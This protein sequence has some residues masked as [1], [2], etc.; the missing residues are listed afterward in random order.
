MQ[1]IRKQACSLSLSKIFEALS[2]SL[3]YCSQPSLFS[4]IRKQRNFRWSNVF[5]GQVI[6][7]C[8]WL[9]PPMHVNRGDTKANIHSDEYPYTKFYLQRETHLNHIK[10]VHHLA[11]LVRG[12]SNKIESLVKLLFVWLFQYYI[13]LFWAI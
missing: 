4:P 13:Q 5:F 7:V 2:N 6:H 9:G 11:I 3:P 12:V 10:A 8:A 1:V